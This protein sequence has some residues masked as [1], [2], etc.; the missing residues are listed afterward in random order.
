MFSLYW[1]ETQEKKNP[2]WYLKNKYRKD[3]QGA[4]WILY[5][6]IKIYYFNNFLSIFNVIDKIN[7]WSKKY[8]IF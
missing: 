5:V 3:F 8:T 4:T 1:K 2:V 7:G 6:A